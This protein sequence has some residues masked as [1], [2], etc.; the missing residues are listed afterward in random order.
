MYNM[1]IEAK[2]DADKSKEEALVELQKC[3][4]LEAKAAEA[5]NRVG[6]HVVMLL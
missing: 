4:K 5:I 1:L 6:L 3:K 2:K